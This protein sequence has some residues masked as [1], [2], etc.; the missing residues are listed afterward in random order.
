MPE[1]IV[2]LLREAGRLLEGADHE[3][4]GGELRAGVRDL[5]LV[6]GEGLRHELVGHRLLVV[7][8]NLQTKKDSNGRVSNSPFGPE[9]E[10]DDGIPQI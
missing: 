4:D 6:E 10:K 1:W 3:A 9:F 8:G 2:V 7:V 5:V